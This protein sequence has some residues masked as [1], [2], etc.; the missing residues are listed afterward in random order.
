MKSLRIPLLFAALGLVSAAAL[1]Q[2]PPPPIAPMEIAG[3]TTVNY[4]G[5]IGLIE[6]TPGLV[7]VDGR[8][9]ADYRKGHI[10]KA[11]NIV[12]DEM[13]EGALASHVA[14]KQKP[15]LF[16]CQGLTCGRAA[17]SVRKAVGW[18]YTKIY[19]YPTGLDEW[20]KQGMP[21]V[22]SK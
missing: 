12:S 3:A 5:V 6:K 16:Y 2:A 13:T 10:E 19:Y 21:L 7:V 15:V 8:L 17:A 4:E 14:T 22:R 20:L 9:L 18:G 1:A 11:I